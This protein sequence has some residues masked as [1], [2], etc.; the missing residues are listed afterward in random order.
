MCSLQKKGEQRLNGIAISRGGCDVPKAGY[1]GDSREGK[2]LCEPHAA[3]MAS[4]SIMNSGSQN[5]YFA[6]TAVRKGV[7][8]CLSMSGCVGLLQRMCE[9]ECINLHAGVE[10]LAHDWIRLKVAT[11]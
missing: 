6:L 3:A 7:R 11:V 8:S 2:L 1:A 5:T 10:D 4:I 9:G